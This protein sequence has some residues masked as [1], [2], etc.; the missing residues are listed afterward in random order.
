MSSSILENVT[1]LRCICNDLEIL[2]EVYDE[3]YKIYDFRNSGKK[4]YVPNL[5]LI[6]QLDRDFCEPRKKHRP[7]I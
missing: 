5:E 6:K 7:L 3:S 1:E 2:K 4:G